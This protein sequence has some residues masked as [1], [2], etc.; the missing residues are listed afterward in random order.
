MKKL[1]IIFL[2]LMAAFLIKPVAALAA[3]HFY[4]EPSNGNYNVGDKITVT[5]WVDPADKDI[6]TMDLIMNYDKTRLSI[7]QSDIKDENYFSPYNSSV[8]NVDSTNGKLS[9]YVFS[10]QGTYSRNTKGKVVTLTFTA[11]AEGTAS[12]LFVCGDENGS[13]IR[14]ADGN[15]IDCTSNG[16]GSYVIAAAANPTPTDTPAPTDAPAPTTTVQPTQTSQQLPAA[17]FSLPIWGTIS[18]A[19]TLIGVG[20]IGLLI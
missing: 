6:Q 4:L 14:N 12:L 1:P 7:D 13:A 8:F 19:A 3:P 18:A 9:L 16:S 11:K 2:F 20:I 15:L 5:V 10:T 17:G